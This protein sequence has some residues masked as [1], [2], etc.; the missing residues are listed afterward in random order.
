MQTP[1]LKSKVF[2]AAEVRRAIKGAPVTDPT[3]PAGRRLLTPW[4]TLWMGAVMGAA[5]SYLALWALPA[6]WTVI[7]CAR[8]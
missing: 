4:Q 5:G 6:I 7:E 3:Q 8:P 2:T 1:K